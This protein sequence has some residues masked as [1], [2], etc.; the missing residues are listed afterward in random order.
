MTET[1]IFFWTDRAGHAY[2]DLRLRGGHWHLEWGY[3]DPPGGDN[4]MQQGERESSVQADA[5][6]WMLD[7]VHAMSDEPDERQR[8]EEK[9]MESLRAMEA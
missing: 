8:V 2:C 7:R 9:L 4:Y 6:A 1:E 3:R 5:V